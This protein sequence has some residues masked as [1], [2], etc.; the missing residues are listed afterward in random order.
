MGG[1][2]W[3]CMSISTLTV[4]VFTCKSM[5]AFIQWM[6]SSNSMEQSYWCYWDNSYERKDVCTR[7]T[8]VQI[9]TVTKYCGSFP[10][11]GTNTANIGTWYSRNYRYLFRALTQVL[12]GT[13]WWAPVCSSQ[14]VT[15]YD[16]KY[17]LVV[18]HIAPCHN[19]LV[20][21]GVSLICGWLTHL[22]VTFVRD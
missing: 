6:W 14:C 1:L 8:S 4:S 12:P 11:P 10:G 13:A 17:L 20:K 22:L 2:V 9:W 5:S 19:Y 15:H 16:I 7:E 3:H 21:C 18:L